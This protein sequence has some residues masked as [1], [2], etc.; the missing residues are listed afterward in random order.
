MDAEILINRAKEAANLFVSSNDFDRYAFR[1]GYL[2]GTIRELTDLLDH[3]EQIMY[4]QRELIEEMK[5][6]YSADL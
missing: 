3:S 6:G 2:E 4:R 1:I 5:K